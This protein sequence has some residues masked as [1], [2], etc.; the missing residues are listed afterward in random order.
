[1]KSLKCV[2]DANVGRDG[3]THGGGMS[4]VN[5]NW[6]F[7]V[8]GLNTFKQHPVDLFDPDYETIAP[9]I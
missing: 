1:M 8:F 2:H 5:Q 3:Q 9:H 7:G 4:D 6:A